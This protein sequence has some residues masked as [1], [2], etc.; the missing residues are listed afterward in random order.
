CILCTHGAAKNLARYHRIE[1]KVTH[2]LPS[3][4]W[5]FCEDSEYATVA[6]GSTTAEKGT[7]CKRLVVLLHST[8]SHSVTQTCSTT[9]N[10]SIAS[11]QACPEADLP[12]MMTQ[13]RHMSV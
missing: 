2:P 10:P 8:Q 6:S 5:V 12:S 13:I 4:L 3:S 7:R 1:S 11:V 9:H